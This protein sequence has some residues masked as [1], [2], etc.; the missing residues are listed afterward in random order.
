LGTAPELSSIAKL[1]STCQWPNRVMQFFTGRAPRRDFPDV[2]GKKTARPG[3]HCGI[4]CQA[5]P[6]RYAVSTTCASRIKRADSSGGVGQ[7]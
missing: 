3:S 5:P 4:G 7:M 6:L 1:R 2:P